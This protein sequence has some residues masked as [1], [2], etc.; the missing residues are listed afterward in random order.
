MKIR[1]RDTLPQANKVF[2]DREE[3]R[4]SFWRLFGRMKDGILEGEDIQ[5]L[6]YYGIG[7]IGKTSLLHQLINE[8]DSELKRPLY[9]YIDFNI[10]KEAGAVLNSL[11]NIL[12]EKYS[13]SFPMFDLAFYVYSKKAGEKIQ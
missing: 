13:F 5:V 9:A 11:R 8:M 3:P 7:G 10:R 12:S 4:K 1:K 6:T 2:T